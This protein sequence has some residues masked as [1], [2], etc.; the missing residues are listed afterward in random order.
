MQKF[1]HKGYTL[2]QSDYNHHC[3]IFDEDGHMVMHVSYNKP[4]TKET[5]IGLIERY[6]FLTG[7]L[8]RSEGE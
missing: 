8:K 7:T 5:A 2:T 3:M 1:T 4:M 6:I